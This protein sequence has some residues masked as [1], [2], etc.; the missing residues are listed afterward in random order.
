MPSNFLIGQIWDKMIQKVGQVVA[1][2]LLIGVLL[3]LAW[4]MLLDKC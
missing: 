3:G 2:Y 1:V 4:G